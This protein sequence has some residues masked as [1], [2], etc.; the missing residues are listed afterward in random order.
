VADVPAIISQ[1]LFDRAQVRLVQNK[2]FAVRNNKTHPYLLRALV[3]CGVCQSSCTCRALDQGKYRYYVCAGKAKAVHSRREEKCPSRFAP[4]QQLEDLVWHDLCQLLQHPEHITHAME[5][6]H[7]GHWL[8][9]EL[10]TRQENLRQSHTRLEHQL[11]RLTE[12]YLVEVISLSE[13]QRRRGD[14]ERKIC[15]SSKQIGQER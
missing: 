10:Q 7:G 1:E 4:A 8:P 13:Y 9:Q 12:A 15:K 11:E 14:I 3:S 2:S 6:A 5:R